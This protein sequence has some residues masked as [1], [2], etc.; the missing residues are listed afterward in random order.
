M[1]VNVYHVNDKFNYTSIR[2]WATLDVFDDRA[3]TRIDCQEVFR[4]GGK[5]RILVEDKYIE[6]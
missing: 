2:N 5:T 6:V 4:G 3:V 1:V